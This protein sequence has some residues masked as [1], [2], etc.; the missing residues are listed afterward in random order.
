MNQDYRG[1]VDKF[2]KL[3]LNGFI[4]A[5]QKFC[6]LSLYEYPVFKE[7]MEKAG[8]PILFLEVENT[9]GGVEAL[10]TRVQAFAEILGAG[11]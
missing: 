3:N 5:T 10:R 6:E 2:K 4:F 7:E 1:V 8:F 9:P 11:N